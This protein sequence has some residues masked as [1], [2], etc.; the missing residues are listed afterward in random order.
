MFLF[1]DFGSSRVTSSGLAPWGFAPWG[2]KRGS[3]RN[4]NEGEDIDGP[5]VFAGAEW[6]IPSLYGARTGTGRGSER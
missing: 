5:V 2:F 3:G 6:V 4:E 1:K